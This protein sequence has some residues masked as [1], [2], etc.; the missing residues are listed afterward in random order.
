MKKMI[1]TKKY[2]ASNH[3]LFKDKPMSVFIG[4]ATLDDD[5][6]P[7]F[8]HEDLVATFTK[9]M[10]SDELDKIRGLKYRIT[11]G[12]EHGIL[13]ADMQAT[14]NCRKLGCLAT[15]GNF[16]ATWYLFLHRRAT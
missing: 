1:E 11:D 8:L 14:T 12:D 15:L 5:D 7:A 13:Y 9:T 4:P 2:F 10:P 6:K 16:L 3:G